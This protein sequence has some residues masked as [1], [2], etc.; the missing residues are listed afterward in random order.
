MVTIPPIKNG[1]DWG[2]CVYGI[3]SHVF[4]KTHITD[5]S[6]TISTLSALA[7]CIL[8]QE[9]LQLIPEILV[10]VVV[11]ECAV[12]IAVIALPDATETLRNRPSLNQSETASVTPKQQCPNSPSTAFPWFSKG[13]LI[14]VLEENTPT[15]KL[16]IQPYSTWQCRTPHFN[17]CSKPWAQYGPTNQWS[18]HLPFASQVEP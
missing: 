1:D 10:A 18:T 9:L 13:D 7:L 17:S 16:A 11:H 4:H 15:S 2:W 14:P 8:I 5:K 12:K 3:V 6:P